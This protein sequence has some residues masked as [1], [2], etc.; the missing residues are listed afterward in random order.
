[1]TRPL[2]TPLIAL[3]A[4]TGCGISTVEQPVEAPDPGLLTEGLARVS[5][6]P[7]VELVEETSDWLG[8]MSACEGTEHLEELDLDGAV[9]TLRDTWQGPCELED[10]TV[11]SGRLVR[12]EDE[13]QTWLAGQSFELQREGETVF[14]L[15]GAIELGGQGDLL[16]VDV[17]ATTCG[18]E[19]GDCAEGVHTLDLT[20]TVFP[21][22]GYPETYDVTVSGVVA[23][24][25]APMGVEGTWS[26]DEAACAAASS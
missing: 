17:A 2:P 18:P 13:Q 12:F 6:E 1:M 14:V 20:W 15:D 24:D 7:W 10:G 22:Q 5:P 16:L 23:T 4:L 19:S 25:D 8:D 11:L 3:F 21:A 9:L 26:I